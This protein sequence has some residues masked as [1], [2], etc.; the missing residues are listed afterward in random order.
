VE[1]PES[2]ASAATGLDRA[3]FVKTRDTWIRPS[4]DLTGLKLLREKAGR[5]R[6]IRELYRGRAP[7]E[8]LQNADDVKATQA[9]FVLVRDGLCFLHDGAWFSVANFKS[10][11]DGWSDK[12]PNQCIGHKGLGFRSVLDLTPSPVVV[13]VHSNWFG[14]KFSWALNQGH[15]NETLR[16]HPELDAEFRSWSRHGQST[17]PVMSIPGEAKKS[18]LGTGVT[19]FERALRGE[20][21]QGL[22]TM[23]WLPASD[24]DAD[25]RVVDSLDVRPV[26][27]NRE[28]V[29][30]LSRFVQR[31]VSTL[32]PFLRCLKTVSFFNGA[33]L[34]VRASL[35]G[36]RTA[37]TGDTIAVDVSSESG[38]AR[39]TYF[40]LSATALIPPQV[41]ADSET[42]RAVRQM[43]QA[44]V[45]LSVR[46]REGAPTFDPDA[47]F[48]VYFPTEEPSGFGVTV[49]GDFYVKP[50]RTRLMPGAYN[51]WLMDIAGRLF[52]GDFL[53]QLL[54]H[55]EAKRVF[56]SLRPSN[57]TQDASGNFRKSV[58]RGF[59]KRKEPFIPSTQ[60][61]L[62]APD[63][64]LPTGS[65][66]V[67]FWS[68]HF[69]NSLAKVTGKTA[70]LDPAADSVDARHFLSFVGV[71]PL[72][73]STILDLIEC[74]AD[75]G[76]ADWWSE[77]YRYLARH[78]EFSRW[79]H[80]VLVGKR[81]LLTAEGTV[82]A[83]PPDAGRVVCFQPTGK[84]AEC[85]VPGRFQSVFVFLNE[86]TV[87][88]RGSET[89]VV[90]D[91]LSR[92]C[93]VAR[94]ESSEIIPRAIRG[95]A[96]SLFSDPLPYDELVGVWR[97]L[98]RILA[99]GRG[100]ES[101]DF[102]LEVGR[103]PLPVSEH[104]F[105]IAPA[106]LSYWPDGHERADQALAG[107]PGLRRVSDVFLAT[108]AGDSDAP[109]TIWLDLLARA[110]VSGTPKVLR[111]VRFVGGGRDIPFVAPLAPSSGEGFTGE[112]QHDENLAVLDELSLS[113]VWKHFVGA[114]A[115]RPG[116]ARALQQLTILEAFERC[117]ILAGQEHAQ[118]NE[119]WSARLWNLARNLPPPA[120]LVSDQVFRRLSGG[121]GANEQCGSFLSMELEMTRWLPSTLG[122]ARPVECFLRMKDR[123]LISRGPTNEELGDLLVPYVVAE[124]LNDYALLTGHGIEPLEEAASPTALVRFLYTVG[125]QFENAQVRD[126]WLLS[127]SRWRLLRG[128]IQESYRTLNHASNTLAFPDDIRLA[129]KLD[130]H[131]GFRERPLFYTEPGS[132][133]E[134]AFRSR[135]A[136]LDADRPYP[137]LFESLGITRL[138]PGQTLDEEVSGADTAVEAP[139]LKASLVSD[140]G[141]YLL[142][143]VIAKAEEQG[144]AE[145][146]RRRLLERF[147]VRVAA[148]IE[149]T[150]T[151]RSDSSHTESFRCPR[152]HLQRDVVDLP[153]AIKETHYTLFVIGTA[154]TSL[155]ALD[156]DA[157]GEA[158]APIYCDGAR[159]DYRAAFPRVV[160]RYQDCRGN[161][162]EMG[163]FLLETLN[164]SLSALDEAREET[165]LLAPPTP[166]PPPATIVTPPPQAAGGHVD[167]DLNQGG[168]ELGR[169]VAELFKDLKNAINSP[170]T[171]KPS[172]TGGSPPAARVSVV[173]KD[174]GRRGE[175][176]FIRRT[177]RAD[178]WEGFVFVK[179]TTKDNCGYDFECRQGSEL[180]YVEVKTFSDDGRVVVSPNE[181]QTAGRLGKSYYLVGFL[182]LG[183]EPAWSSA[184]IR[185]PFGPLIEKGSFDLDIVLEIR[186]KDLFGR[187]LR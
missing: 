25:K 32:L 65:D 17:C 26:T 168:Q 67:G 174:R 27:A 9:V 76:T 152:F 156:G 118:E 79:G 81:L 101:D 44:N 145:L 28:G 138:I 12:D 163:R 139:V 47:R 148:D 83:V 59:Q 186:P 78:D 155:A 179:D 49:H 55:Y 157:L 133:A 58:V 132:P 94:F 38:T 115:V 36:D 98:Q 128:A 91:W 109:T 57:A 134:R 60:G 53:S 35:T 181:L 41:K 107:I 147:E 70:F 187:D 23:F 40:Q 45:R 160:A 82:I 18:S 10:L 142:A 119:S 164:V 123:R 130:E 129:S 162:E 126:A 100:V 182:D 97:F 93:R 175:D 183:P 64:G 86:R 16:Q 68:S 73:A 178:G 61:P 104:P 31:D 177:Q 14:F 176:E 34:G 11:A 169:R 103:L 20:L 136:F 112:R 96:Q 77:V 184:I 120:A 127:R 105:S 185:D 110:G 173:Q 5:E 4:F 52:A 48:H 122:P 125:R 121:G 95:V 113:G 102:W 117:C 153:G 33:S 13:K 150:F 140:L 106:F 161:P 143:I 111:F 172:G 19:V 108:L 29:D 85:I 71:Q 63:V 69:E 99:L 74:S 56:E 124:S 159:D 2:I 171:S 30:T 43:T 170:P 7:Y 37:S 66:Q 92:A 180:V 89:D 21:G 166:P 80:G 114:A 131:L 158:L 8:L 151:L 149:L 137:T 90:R 24:P 39:A 144:H 167:R 146:V 42:P 116:D 15:I 50:D 6:D 165:I 1:I 87:D 154:E 135:L 3:S 84:A 141:P 62:P 22:T 51:E 46:T 54:R 88:P 72:F 75:E